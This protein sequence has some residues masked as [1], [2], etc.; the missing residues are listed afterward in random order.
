MA[1]T[2]ILTISDSGVKF[3]GKHL[4]QA[5]SYILDREKTQDGRLVT[6][7][8]C[9]PGRAYEQSGSTERRIRGRDTTSSFP[10]RRGRL[11]RKLLLRLYRSLRR[12]IW[13]RDMRLSLQSMTIPP[14]STG[15]SYLTA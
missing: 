7:I 9:Q 10:L 15:I 6:G 8:N 12:N 5:V 3:A 2:K 11:H 14:M 13:G 1:I 4:E